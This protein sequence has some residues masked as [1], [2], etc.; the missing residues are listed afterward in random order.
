MSFEA[1]YFNFCSSGGARRLAGFS[2]SQKGSVGRGEQEAAL[3]N[4]LEAE[5]KLLLLAPNPALILANDQGLFIN[6]P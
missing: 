4:F 5:E 3:G 2:S 1:S 6:D